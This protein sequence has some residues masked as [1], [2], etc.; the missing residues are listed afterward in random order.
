MLSVLSS[1]T[2]YT[3]VTALRGGDNEAAENPALLLQ[4]F[5]SIAL[6][7]RRLVAALAGS[8]A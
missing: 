8:A 7:N 1:H 5:C 4:Q 2:R 3:Q 6:R